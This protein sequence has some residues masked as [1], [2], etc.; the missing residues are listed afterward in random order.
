M[1]LKRGNEFEF[2]TSDGITFSIEGEAHLNWVLKRVG[3]MA[4]PDH[5]KTHWT[6][7]MRKAGDSDFWEA[8]DRKFHTIRLRN[9]VWQLFQ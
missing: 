6:Y 8:N 4:F 2:L 5:K 3:R 9:E 1:E 7:R